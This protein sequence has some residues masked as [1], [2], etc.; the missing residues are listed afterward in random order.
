MMQ[1]RL[2]L[3]T[4]LALLLALAG[5]AQAALAARTWQVG[6]ERELRVPSQ[7]ARVAESGDTVE[8]DA[9]QYY[10]DY[11]VWN[12]DDLTIRGVDGIAKLGSNRL[13]PN[14][15]GIWIINGKNLVL[16]NLEFSGARVRDTNGAGIRHQ[17][18]SLTIRNAY[19]HHNEFSILTGRNTEAD[20]DISNSRFWYQQRATR[21]SHGIYIGTVRRFTLTGSHFKGTDQGHQIKSRALENFIAY[22]RI[23]EKE[24]GGSSRLIDLPNCGRSV[25]MGNDMHQ[26]AAT[27]NMEIIGYGAEGCEER[28]AAQK[29]LFVVNNTLVNEA[30]AGTLVSNHAEDAYALIANNLVFGRAWLLR[31]PGEEHDNVRLRLA[32]RVP[33]SWESP[34]GAESIDAAGSPTGAETLVPVYEFLPPAGVQ[35]RPE[36]GPLDIGSREYRTQPGSG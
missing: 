9:G 33:E 1:H 14:D 3:L 6:P 19:F 5:C 24:I 13:I 21:F 25:V 36:I 12:Q 28:S 8:I 20:I 4:R 30:I 2:Q 23:E 22:N 7:A 31:G 34:E 32:R 35:R 17:G 26:G 29:R 10:N 18:G 11:A 16:E 27:A 15:K